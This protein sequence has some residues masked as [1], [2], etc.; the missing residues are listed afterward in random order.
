MRKFTVVDKNHQT[1]PA[2]ERVLPPNITDDIVIF[3]DTWL[4]D[5][6]LIGEDTEVAVVED[7]NG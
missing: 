1:L 2:F 5:V 4:R 3:F 7:C 6:G